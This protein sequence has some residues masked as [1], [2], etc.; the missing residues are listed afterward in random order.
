M[1]DY[2]IGCWIVV[3]IIRVFEVLGG[4]FEFVFKIVFK[5]LVDGSV[6]F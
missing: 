4:C 1:F 3:I 6:G 2:V 5:V